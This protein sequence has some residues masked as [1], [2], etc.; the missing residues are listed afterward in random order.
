VVDAEVVEAPDD[1]AAEVVGEVL[2]DAVDVLSGIAGVGGASKRM[3]TAKLTVSGL[4]SDTVLALLMVSTVLTVSSGSGLGAHCGVSPLAWRGLCGQCLPAI[5]LAH[6]E[7]CRGEQSP[8][9][10][11]AV[12]ADGST[13]RVLIRRLNSS[14][15]RWRWLCVRSSIG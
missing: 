7:L 2:L 6:V 15:S 14:C 10:M 12:S 5:H 9:L 4:L 13:V 3:N 8:E 1:A 11:A